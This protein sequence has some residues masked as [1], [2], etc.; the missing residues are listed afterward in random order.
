MSGS[1]PGGGDS[2]GAGPGFE[3]SDIELCAGARACKSRVGTGAESGAVVTIV[4]LKV[5]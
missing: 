3:V 2:P 4:T 1:T 5:R